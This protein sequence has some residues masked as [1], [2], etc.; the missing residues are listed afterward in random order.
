MADYALGVEWVH[1]CCGHNQSEGMPAGVG[2]ELLYFNASRAACCNSG[3]PGLR[4]RPGILK[5]VPYPL[6]LRMAVET[7]PL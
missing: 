4:L 5:R 7:P 6:G 1:V 3:A 2:G